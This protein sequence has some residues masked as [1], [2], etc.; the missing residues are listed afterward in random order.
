MKKLFMIAV[1]FGCIPAVT[2]CGG[3]EPTVIEPVGDEAQLEADQMKMYE[4]QMKSGG[5][6]RSTA[7][8]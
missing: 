6:S 4:E 5:S 7:S 1:L 2:G 3:N 8:N